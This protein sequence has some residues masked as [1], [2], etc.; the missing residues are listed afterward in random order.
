M[1]SWPLHHYPS[2][3]GSRHFY[4]R[5]WKATSLRYIIDHNKILH[6]VIQTFYFSEFS[7]CHQ[8][9]R[10]GL[11]IFSTLFKMSIS[12]HIFPL[13]QLKPLLRDSGSRQN[14]MSRS[15]GVLWFLIAVKEFIRFSRTSP[16]CCVIDDSSKVN[17]TELKW[18][19]H[20]E[21]YIK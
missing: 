12:C 18:L 13:H 15:L 4:T 6:W 10:C 5:N 8:K 21:D 9:G 3:K 16:C 11:V 14:V 20:S 7:G 17:G 2:S 19:Q 1:I